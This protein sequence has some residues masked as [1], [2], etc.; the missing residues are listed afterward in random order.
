MSHAFLDGLGVAQVIFL[1]KSASF[2]NIARAPY[3]E[4]DATKITGRLQMTLSHLL[5]VGH[6]DRASLRSW[7]G[8]VF[9]LR[10]YDSMRRTESVNDVSTEETSGTEDGSGMSYAQSVSRLLVV[11][12]FRKGLRYLLETTYTAR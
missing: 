1:D 5:A 11:V 2:N 6:N 10:Q 4:V 7:S 3:N 12:M 8:S 9:L